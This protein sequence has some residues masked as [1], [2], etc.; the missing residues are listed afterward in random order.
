[1]SCIQMK[2]GQ[3]LQAAS[4]CL[5]KDIVE[6][7]LHSSSGPIAVAQPVATERANFTRQKL[8]RVEAR[9]NLLG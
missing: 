9:S 5:L 3:S 4:L 1:M 8:R 6:H 7:I 2:K